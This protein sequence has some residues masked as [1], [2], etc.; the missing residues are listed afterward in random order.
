MNIM[1][2]SLTVLDCVHG[3]ISFAVHAQT[4]D[5]SKL[6]L[7]YPPDRHKHNASQCMLAFMLT[8]QGMHTVNTVLSIL[9]LLL[10]S[11]SAW[12]RPT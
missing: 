10:H 4:A 2:L 1:S 7:L 3:I 11:T 9:L 12:T 8:F 6:V 5:P